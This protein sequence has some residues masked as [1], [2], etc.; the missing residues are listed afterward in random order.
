MAKKATR[1]RYTD[2]EKKKILGIAEKEN[3][4]GAEVQKRFKIAQLTFYRWRGPV[5][6]PK[7][8]AAQAAGGLTRAATVVG[9]TAG[10]A[11]AGIDAIRA[12]VRSGVRA[13]IPNVIREEVANYLSE[14]LGRR[15]PGRPKGSGRG[16]GRPKG[17][18]RGPGR[19]K[20]SGIG[21]GRPAK[22]K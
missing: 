12:E 8:R 2:A 4:T 9:R 3:L 21:P 6:G 15:K 18:G 11:V 1:R 20:G 10:Q 19:P 17:T 22:K 14:I 13:V 16:P 5:R 7:A